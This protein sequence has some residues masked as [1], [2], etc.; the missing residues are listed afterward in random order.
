MQ[1]RD[2]SWEPAE[3]F[4]TVKCRMQSSDPSLCESHTCPKYDF[5][6]R[7]VSVSANHSTAGHALGRKKTPLER[8]FLRCIAITAS[9]LPLSPLGTALTPQRTTSFR[10]RQNNRQFA[11]KSGSRYTIARLFWTAMRVLS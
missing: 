11:N 2:D 1:R 9:Q 6:K 10:N 7:G 5:E 8:S 4:Y 3:K